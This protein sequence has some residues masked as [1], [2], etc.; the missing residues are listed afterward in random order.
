[1]FHFAHDQGPL[2]D[3]ITSA[4]RLDEPSAVKNLASTLQFDTAQKDDIRTL[5]HRLITQV[6]AD[7]SKSSGVDAL[8]QE[9]SLSSE[10]GVA[11]MCLAESLLRIPDTATRDKLIQDKLSDG[12]WKSHVGNSPSMFVNAAAWGLVLTGKLT[13]PT[14]DSLGSALTRI[15]Q[16]GGAPFI[17]AGVNHAMKILGQQFVTGQTINEALANG[18]E[19]EKLGYRFSFDMLGEAAMTAEDADRYYNDY[20]TAIHAIGKDAKGRGVYDGNGISVKLSAIHPRYFRAQ[21]ERVMTELL[22]RLKALFVLAKEYNIGLNIDAEE[23]NRLELSLDLME[24]LVSDPDLAGF[25]GIGFVVQA[26]QKRCPYVIDYL[27]DLARRNN[28]KLMIRLVKGAYWDSE[29]KWAQVDGMDGYPV[30]TRKVHTDVSY[31]ACAKKLLAAQDA[32]FPQF[33][34]HNAQSLATIYKMGEGKDFEFQCLH[35][36]GETL[37]DQVVGEKNLGRRVRIY[38]PVGTHK[39]LLAYL[40]RRLLE[41]GANSSFVNRI[42]DEKVSIDALTISPLDE[43]DVNNITAN[44]LTPK[45]RHIYGERLNSYGIDLSNEHILAELQ[46]NM[47]AALDINFDISSITSIPV[48]HNMAHDVKNPADNND[49]VGRVSFLNPICVH[50]VITAT[51]NAQ[52]AWQATT[53]KARADVLRRFADTLESPKHMALLMMIAMREAGKTLSNAIAE[54]REAV[55]F[56]R[57]YADEV[58]RLNLNSPLGTVIAISPWNFPLAIFVG[59]VVSA[60]AAGNTVVAKPAEQTSI[61]AH[62][63]VTWLHEAGVPTDALQLVLGA[64]DVG[65]ALTTDDRIDGVIFTGSTEVAKRINSVLAARTDNP[66]LIAE[67]G[68]MN[69]MIV[70]STAL[71]EQVCTD[72]LASAFDSAGQRCSALR[73]LCIQEDI[74]DHMIEMIK[75]AM[76]ELVVNSPA[77]LS[78]DVGPVIDAEAQENLLNHINTLKQTAGYHEVKI[79]SNSQGTFVAPIM[80]ELQNLSQ[81]KKEVFGP[82][83]HVV[84]FAAHELNDLIDDINKKGFALT[85]GIH[86]R[87]DGTINHI[88]SRIEAGN[89]YIN[90]NIVGAVVGVQPFG[91]HGMSGTGPKAGGPFY[92]Q[93]L[94][95]LNI[96]HTPNIDD[97]AQIDEQALSHTIT[98]AKKLGITDSEIQNL[99]HIANHAKASSLNGATITLPGPTGERNTLS[100][101]APYAVTIYGGNLVQSLN[102]L[103]ILAANG[104]QATITPKHVLSTHANEFDGIITVT[105]QAGADA[106]DIIIALDAMPSEEQVRLAGLDGTIRRVIDATH[107]LDIAR[108][109]HE[110]SQSYNTTA[111]GGNASLMASA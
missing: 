13:Q 42:V 95:R 111:A 2:R 44:P 108:L 16:K 63:A 30:Y 36:M 54:V 20:V 94:S 76:D 57:Y 29:I 12:D 107:G 25:N 27:I 84:R 110:I 45:P 35:G 18:K 22:P 100:W 37:Y 38:A 97:L 24:K 49:I 43:I 19:R 32:I 109:Y 28:Q 69:A 46:A 72:V 7:R 102:V 11:L 10:E 83:L 81:L 106:N 87:I 96:W 21:H 88:A 67:T 23:A 105:E 89:V 71:P 53:P 26:Y 104:I 52:G 34:T 55:D 40:V 8:M 48:Q 59:E 73:I 75:G 58:E 33:A 91:G 3:A 64:G 4:Y 93:R 86:S 1:M 92:L 17:R 56:C 41:N 80:F 61:I 77:L 31:L 103:A 70:D 78:T 39:T 6:R 90:R 85:H 79:R 68:G 9:F 5:A 14:N 99:N 82:V 66:V 74:A 65:G 60:L 50:D 15:I 62:L 51:I 101:R 98:V 47:N